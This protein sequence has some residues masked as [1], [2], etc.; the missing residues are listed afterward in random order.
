MLSDSN[1]NIALF[2]IKMK[3]MV[4]GNEFRVFDKLLRVFANLKKVNATIV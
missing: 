4:Y 1:C 3:S 2:S